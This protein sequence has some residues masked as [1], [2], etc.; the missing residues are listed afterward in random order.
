MA[1]LYSAAGLIART[2]GR[3]V[4]FERDNEGTGGCGLVTPLGAS[5]HRRAIF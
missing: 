4:S 5:G 2:L 1:P 3:P